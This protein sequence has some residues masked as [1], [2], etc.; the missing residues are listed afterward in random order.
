MMNTEP[1]QRKPYR[2]GQLHPKVARRRE[3]I[4]AIIACRPTLPG[5]YETVSLLARQG[6]KTSKTAVH[7]D[8]TTL[9]L[10]NF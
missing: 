7:V 2:N 4:K 6:I 9:G 1:K 5:V 10:S 3:A 8:Y